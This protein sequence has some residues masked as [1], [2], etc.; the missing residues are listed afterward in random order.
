MTRLTTSWRRDARCKRAGWC[1]LPR[2]ICRAEGV[3]LRLLSS[4][5]ELQ[6]KYVTRSSVPAK[7]GNMR[8]IFCGLTLRYLPYEASLPEYNTLYGDIYDTNLYQSKKTVKPSSGS[9]HIMTP[10]TGSGRKVLQ[11]V[12]LSISALS[13]P[14][15][16][17]KPIPSTHWTTTFFI[18]FFVCNQLDRFS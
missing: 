11:I 14:N 17:R 10:N 18:V 3:P 7:L 6:T 5:L 15:P 9:G 1:S 13:I 12:N 4:P 2:S 8:F 16:R